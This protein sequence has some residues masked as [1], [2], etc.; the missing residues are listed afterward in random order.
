MFKKLLSKVSV[1]LAI[2]FFIGSIS[3]ANVLAAGNNN[4][5]GDNSESAPIVIG[6]DSQDTLP[7]DKVSTIDNLIEITPHAAQIL[8]TVTPQ[9]VAT[10]EGRY[11]IESGNKNDFVMVDL[12]ICNI[13]KD[14]IDLDEVLKAN[15][16][17]DGSYT[18]ETYKRFDS[19]EGD[20]ETLKFN[21]SMYGTWEGYYDMGDYGG[22]AKATLRL[23]DT[24]LDGNMVGTFEY[25]PLDMGTDY[26][27]NSQYAGSYSVITRKSSTLGFCVYANEWLTKPEWSIDPKPFWLW[28]V[29]PGVLSGNSYRSNY[30]IQDNDASRGAICLKKTEPL[31]EPTMIDVLQ[32]TKYSLVFNCPNRVV[33]NLDKC[34]LLIEVND[35]VYEIPLH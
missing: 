13:S 22:W 14:E 12:D 33:N 21:E 24:D 29:A 23:T 9:A 18:F 7:L 32:E 1:F 8:D 31:L 10:D 11:G 3:S 25:E 35:N 16:I 27:M 17:F 19:N 28:P 26:I 4:D 2:T 30:Y 5:D 6:A 15:L 34:Q 20:D